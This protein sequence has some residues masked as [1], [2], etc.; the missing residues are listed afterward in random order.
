[1]AC[2]AEDISERKAAEERAAFLNSLLRH[3]L[4]NKLQVARSRIELALDDDFGTTGESLKTALANVDE[5]AE[6]IRT[7]RALDRL[8]SDADVTVEVDVA[9]APRVL[10]GDLIK[11]LVANLAMR[12]PGSEPDGDV[13]GV[14][15]HSVRPFRGCDSQ[16]SNPWPARS[17]LRSSLRRPGFEPGP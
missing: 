5:A 15:P 17:S 7:V 10:P 16:G 1:M 12:R 8:R 14:R 4:G 3:D 13:P 9:S 6:P 2:V 11:E